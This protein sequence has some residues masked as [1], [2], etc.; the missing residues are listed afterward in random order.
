MRLFL[1]LLLVISGSLKSTAQD[2]NPTQYQLQSD[3]LTRQEINNSYWYILDDEEGKLS[4][5][6][7]MKEP[8]AS[9]FIQLENGRKATSAFVSTHWIKYSVK[10]VMDHKAEICFY[11]AAERSDFYI[12]RQN[13]KREHYITGITYPWS[14]KDGLKSAN[15][16]PW[17]MMAGE[18]VVVYQRRHNKRPDSLSANTKLV[19]MSTE[20]L[21]T[22][23]LKEYDDNSMPVSAVFN[24]FFS[25]LFLLAAIFNIL[26]FWQLKEK[27]NLY[28]SLFL[29]SMFLLYN[30]AFSELIYRENTKLG[31]FISVVSI[32]FLIWFLLFVNTYFQLSTHFRILVRVLIFLTCAITFT[33]GYITHRDSAIGQILGPILLIAYVMSLLVIVFLGIRK[34]GEKARIFIK[35]ILPFLFFL[36]VPILV[37]TVLNL[38]NV[39]VSSFNVT[40]IWNYTIGGSIAWAACVF[41]T[42][43]Y[44]NYGLQQQKIVQGMLLTERMEREKEQEKNEFI[45]AQKI[46]L[47][48]QVA[49]RTLELSNS[50]DALRSAQ[51]Q[52]I[53]SE[54]MASLGELTAGI[55]HEI[56][57]PL[58][59]VNNFSEVNQEL[60]EE[61]EQEAEKGNLKE[62]QLL[63]R[64]IKENE[65]K[66]N[67]H[68]KRADAIVKNMLQHSRAADGAKEATNINALADE[69]LRLAYHGLRAKDKSFNA[70]LQM[71][72]DN[73]VGL[74]SVVPQ[75][76]GRVLLN[77]FNN[78][79][80]AVQK[81]SKSGLE[82]YQP[83]V[84]LKTEKTA[85][86]VVITVTDNG[87]GIPDGIKD[88]IFQPFF[89]TKPTGEG[90]GLGL[91]LSYDIAKAHGGKL[92]VKSAE[93]EGTEF[94]I[95][96]PL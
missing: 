39:D 8:L 71:N 59:F 90:T 21:R 10:N 7:V 88:K 84:S 28:F 77:L 43:L 45:L 87:S 56:Q 40:E 42:Y 18:E 31:E 41:S 2:L 81:K 80:Y 4:I 74:V 53:Q 89:T 33:L 34:R 6:D 49:E 14:K 38:L 47:E 1:F 93:G 94:S 79:F 73:S 3:T 52:L 25:G 24:S 63:A 91:S 86:D 64:D 12:F 92:M 48:K 68:G 96:L 75:E 9:E 5:D 54:K 67:H 16:I 57:N 78:A 26:L 95:S 85:G 60:A 20:K 58:N 72:L 35:A 23:E 83:V 30:P 13:N 70:D 51:S 11:T 76:I 65:A 66:I 61:L 44:K 36:I 37:I 27:E 82:N 15:A 46:E 55:A 22:A 32:S 62:V 19:L 69:Y 17:N 50:L 29:F